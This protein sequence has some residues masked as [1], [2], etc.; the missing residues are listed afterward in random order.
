M[1]KIKRIWISLAF[2][3]IFWVM[4]II[5]A[6]IELNSYSLQYNLLYNVQSNTQIFYSDDLWNYSEEKSFLFNVDNGEDNPIRVMVEGKTRYLRVDF[7][8]KD[9][10]INVS[11]L[12][13]GT[14][15]KSIDLTDNFILSKNGVDDLSYSDSCYN[16]S[17]SGDDPYIVFDLDEPLQELQ[18]N[19]NNINIV[20]KLVVTLISILF[21]FIIYKNHFT[22]KTDIKWL[23]N[24]LQEWNRIEKL[25]VNDFKMRYAASYLGTFWAFVQPVVT[26]TIYSVIFGLGFKSLPVQGVS[27][28]LWLTIGIV[29]WF[30]FSESLLAAT[31]SLI[32]YSYLVKKV[33]FGVNVL[34]IVKIVSSS[35]I[36]VFFCF[37][38]NNHAISKP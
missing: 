38:C 37:G 25:A 28:P 27:F 9:N 10:Y 23:L 18:I 6:R 22:L 15:L 2:S 35:F 4:L 26:V 3:F 14:K 30:F 33:V 36:H 17:V 16:I 13:I 29:P 1:K 21:F 34:P 24:I 11:N 5:C 7:G 31:N 12:K 8:D 19:L 20:L 32:E